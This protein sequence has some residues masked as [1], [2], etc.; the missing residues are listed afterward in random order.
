MCWIIACEHVSAS[1]VVK[2]VLV[3]AA[4]GLFT[5]FA[6]PVCIGTI[7]VVTLVGVTQIAHESTEVPESSLEQEFGKNPGKN[8]SFTACLKEIVLYNCL[9]GSLYFCF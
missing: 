1:A 4:F 9:E 7:T 6:E 5:L 8:V 2:T 3:P